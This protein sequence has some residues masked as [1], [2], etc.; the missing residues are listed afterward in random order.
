MDIHQ[1]THAV[2]LMLVLFNPLLM[3]AY[4]HDL[5][6][7]LNSSDFFLVISRA[8]VISGTVFLLFAWIGDSVFSR[9]LQVRFAAFLIFGGIVFL[10]IA[11][12]YII[13]GAEM[14]GT[15]RGKAE[16]L[17]GAVAMPFMI[18]PGT[19][20]ASVLIGARMP[21]WWSALAIVLALLV[22]CLILVAMKSLFDF[23]Q[24]RNERLL[25]RYLDI[26]GRISALIIGTIALDMIM[27]GIDL[28]LASRN[29]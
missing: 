22:S 18:G 7:Q 12:R 4:L 13:N 21:L 17:A 26:T 19:V 6:K 29:T 3:T 16:H 2:V 28:W 24:N 5:M 20:S 15:L 25:E 14:I 27:K 8:F 11:L 23:I 10:I 9:V 1:F